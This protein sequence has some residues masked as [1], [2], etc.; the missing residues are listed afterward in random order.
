MVSILAPILANIVGCGGCSV[1]ATYLLDREAGALL[2]LKLSLRVT[3]LPSLEFSRWQSCAEATYLTILAVLG[4]VFCYEIW[5]WDS[6]IYPARR[7]G[8]RLGLLNASLS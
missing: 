4:V 1:R 3:G 7:S 5:W 8:G 2:A 6:W